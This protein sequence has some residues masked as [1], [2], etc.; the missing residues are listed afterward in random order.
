MNITYVGANGSDH[1]FHFL[2]DGDRPV[3]EIY[4]DE[5]AASNSDKPNLPIRING[6]GHPL[7]NVQVTKG[8]THAEPVHAVKDGQDGI[9]LHICVGCLASYVLPRIVTL[10]ARVYVPTVV[11]NV[12]DVLSD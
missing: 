4:V 8:L 5:N 3:L 2:A 10:M 9:E 6:V 1:L 7:D 12:T 11:D